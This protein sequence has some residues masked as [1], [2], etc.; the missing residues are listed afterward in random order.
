MGSLGSFIATLRPEEVKRGVSPDPRTQGA[1]AL[2][3]LTERN[4]ANPQRPSRMGARRINAQISLS[5]S[6]PCFPDGTSHWPTIQQ[7]A[8]REREFIDVVH[9]G[10]L[11][12]EE[13]VDLRGKWK[14][15]LIPHDQHR[16]FQVYTLQKLFQRV[17]K[18][19]CTDI[20][21]QNC[22]Q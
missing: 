15:P 22:S 19:T 17:Y 3:S 13:R 10:Q 5:S 8:S 20:V 9:R 14:T 1:A 18:R 4:A 2:G 11:S 6:P 21:V 7:E 12:V 16:Y